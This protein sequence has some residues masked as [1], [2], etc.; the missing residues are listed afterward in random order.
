ML[1][2][3]KIDKLFLKKE[4]KRK[5]EKQINNQHHEKKLKPKHEHELHLN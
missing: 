4:A 2:I 3:A 1:E 5:Q